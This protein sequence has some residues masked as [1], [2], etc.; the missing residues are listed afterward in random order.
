MDAGAHVF[1]EVPFV[2]NLEIMR[3][4]VRRAPAYSKVLAA[5]HSFRMYPPVRLIR[6][7]VCGGAIGKPLYLE[8]SLGQHV[9][10]W[11]SYEHY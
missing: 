8:H 7:L 11:H 2:L 3:D 6:D 5:S 4:I 1:A 10:G 9:A